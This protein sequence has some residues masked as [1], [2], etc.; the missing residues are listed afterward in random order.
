MELVVVAQFVKQHA[1]VM[2]YGD[3]AALLV[4]SEDPIPELVGCKNLLN[5]LFLLSIGYLYVFVGAN[6]YQ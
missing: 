4:P 5:L 1:A 2:H 6:M 3:D